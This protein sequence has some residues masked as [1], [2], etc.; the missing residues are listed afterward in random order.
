MGNIIVP[1]TQ[2]FPSQA[3]VVIIGGGVLGAATAFYASQAGLDAVVLE[4]RDSLGS[5]TTAASE[6]CFRAQFSEPENVAMMKA[7][8]AVFENFAEVIGIPGYD[9]NLHQQ[10]YLFFTADPSGPE[11]LQAQVAHQRSIG[12]D[13]VEFWTGDE[14]RHH[15]PW[16]SPLVTAATWRAKDGWLSAHELTY[17]FAKGSRARFLLRT[18]VT[19]LLVDN[20]GVAGVETNRGTI[21]TRTVVIAAGPFSGKVAQL[22]GVEL[23]LTLLRRQKFIVAPHPEIPQN[24]PMTI[25]LNSGAFWRPEVGGAALGWA[26][27]LPEQPAE[28][29]E[30]VPT[31]WTFP[32]LVLEEV[33]KLSPF[34]EKVAAELKR[35]DVFLSAGQYTITPDHKPILGPYPDVPGLFLNVGY[36]GHGVMGSPEGSRYVVATITGELRPEDNPFSY[37]RFAH[38]VVVVSAEKMVL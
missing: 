37:E 20:L 5:L 34:W 27:A 19:G 12:L 35:E 32:P 21:A 7:S 29:L 6:E 9:I 13:D 25:D 14:V 15:F 22:A 10:G 30:K 28:P 16:A 36:S 17:G 38:G 26:D 4:M 33:M 2:T 31:E 24:G 8:I 23:P 3:E 18:K 1:D 11:K